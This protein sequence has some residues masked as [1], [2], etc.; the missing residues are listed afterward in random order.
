MGNKFCALTFD[1]GPNTVTTPL[2]IDKLEKYG[3]IASFFLVGN[4]ITEASAKVAKRAFELGC[5][6]N[7]HSRTHS[8]MPELAPD[9]IRA[10]IAFTSGKIKE[11]TGCEPKFFRPPYIAVNDTMFENIDLPF[12]AGFGAEDWKDEVSAEERAEKVLAQMRNGCVILLHDMEGNSKTAWA[13]D[14]IIPALLKDGYE[15]VTVSGLFEKT[16]VTPKKGIV[17]SYTEQT[18]TYA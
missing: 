15:F 1:D 9:E 18:T 5:E 17:Y 14:L 12:I 11:I 8:A 16:G 13:L 3:V 7:N 4:N 10:E 2:V 6:I